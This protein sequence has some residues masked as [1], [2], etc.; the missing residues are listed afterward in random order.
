MSSKKQ[1][2]A[3]LLGSVESCMKGGEPSRAIG[4]YSSE[5]PNRY[6]YFKLFKFN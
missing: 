2:K 6:E 5:A 3:K 1:S 4:V